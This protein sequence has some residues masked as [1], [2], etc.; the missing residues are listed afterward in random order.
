MASEDE[1]YLS[2]DTEDRQPSPI[3]ESELNFWGVKC[4]FANLKER[5][6]N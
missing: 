1:V 3:Q 2:E 4:K 6:N 5:K